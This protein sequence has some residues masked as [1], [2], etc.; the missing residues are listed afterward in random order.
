[1][2][3]SDILSLLKDYLSLALLVVILILLLF[4]FFYKIVYKKFMHGKKEIKFKKLVLPLIFTMYITVLLGATF[5]NRNYIYRG[6]INLNLF[7]SYKEAYVT[8]SASNWRNIILNIL[9]F[10]PMGFLLPLL[11]KHL[12]KCYK[13]IG[14]SFIITLIIEIVQA[15]TKLGIFE[16][17]DI[18]NNLLGSIIGY[19]FINIIFIIKDKESNKKTLKILANLLPLVITICSFASIFTVYHFQEFGNLPII[20]SSKIDMKNVSIENKIG[21]IGNEN[22]RANIYQTKMYSKEELKQFAQNTFKTLGS[23]ISEDRDEI[24]Y[25]Q[26]AIFYSDNYQDM[27]IEYLGRTYSLNDNHNQIKLYNND[28]SSQSNNDFPSGNNNSVSATISDFN[29][30]PIRTDVSK[31]EIIELIAKAGVNL[32]FDYDYEVSNNGE[33]IFKV[34]KFIKDDFMINGNLICSLETSGNYCIK[35]NIIEYHKIKECEIISENEA[36]EII[37]KRKFY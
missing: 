22:K 3:I 35:N 30:D 6:D 25:E 10:F 8:A 9:L 28:S 31:E 27:W 37:K 15:I 12:K 2:R 4:I 7:S 26:T 23:N 13:T 20:D 29:P 24:Y 16:I 11:N 5:L 36:F 21:N 18:F 34:N 14:I 19:T 33:H 1:M 17:D 32:D